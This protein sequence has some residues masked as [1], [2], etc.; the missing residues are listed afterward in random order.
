MKPNKPKYRHE[1][2]YLISSWEADELSCR[3]RDVIPLD[4]HVSG[5]REYMIRSLYFDDMWDTAY[6]EKMGGS[7]T[8][9][10]Y[11]IRVYNCEDTLIKLECKKKKGQ[12]IH[13]EAAA[14]SRKETDAIIG[15]DFS[16]L[17]DRKE[18]VCRE[19]YLKC[20]CDGMKPKVIVDYDREPYAGDAGEVRITLDKRVRAGIL[21][22]DLFDRQLPSLDCMGKDEI[23]LEV[24]Y[25][26]FLPQVLR[27]ILPPENSQLTAYSKYVACC[28]K[29]NELLI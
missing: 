13:K 18:T 2:K 19:F 12:Y 9:E 10:K 27:N 25:T 26:E 11:R 15:G 28:D 4:R 21:D 23:I 5:G 7:D 6:E 14:L 8:R 22:F 24:K 20:L 3:I 1:L 29:R 16:F 17:L